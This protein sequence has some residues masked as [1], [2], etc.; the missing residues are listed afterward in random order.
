MSVSLLLAIETVPCVPVSAES[1]VQEVFPPKVTLASMLIL[2]PATRLMVPVEVT[3]APIFTLLLEP[4]AVMATVPAPLAVTGPLIVTLPL[5][6]ARVMA[7]P[8]LEVML[9]PLLSTMLPP[10]AIVK[11]KAPVLLS[12]VPEL[13]RE[14]RV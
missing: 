14:S 6:V 11:L 3:V 9:E 5:T 4:P 2:S 13:V 7:P 8:E 12:T 10:L 1:A